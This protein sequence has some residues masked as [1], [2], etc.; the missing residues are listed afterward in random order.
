MGTDKF[1]N[2][3]RQIMLVRKLQTVCDMAYYNLCTLF[4]IQLVMRVYARLVLGEECRIH[5]FPY[6]V[7]HGSRTY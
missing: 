3:R 7:I 5:H 1:F 4:V 6:I 2:H